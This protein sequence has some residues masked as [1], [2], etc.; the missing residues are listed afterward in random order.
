[1]HYPRILIRHQEEQS[2]WR[3]IRILPERRETFYFRVRRRHVLQ[4]GTV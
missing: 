2:G 1:M 3:F 4:A